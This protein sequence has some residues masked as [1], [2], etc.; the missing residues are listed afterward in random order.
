[1]WEILPLCT[2]LEFYTQGTINSLEEDSAEDLAGDR[3]K[4][5]V[6]PVVAVA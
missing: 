3:Q 5:F 6:S 1:M 2:F 4:C